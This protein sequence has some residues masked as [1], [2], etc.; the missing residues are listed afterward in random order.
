MDATK[1]VLMVAF[2]FPPCQSAGVQRT[3]K[4]C[5]YLP[6]LGWQPIVLTVQER[7]HAK[8][9]TRLG[10]PEE[11]EPFVF[12]AFGLDTRQHLSIKGKYLEMMARPDQFMTWYRPAVALGKKLI[13]QYQPDA[14]WSTFPYSTAHRIACKLHSW[15]GLPWIADFRDPFADLHTQTTSPNRAA[16]KVDESAVIAAQQLVF[17]TQKT[18]EL[19]LSSYPAL[20]Q[21][22]VNV[23]ENGY[24]EEVFQTVAAR[25]QN[26]SETAA[27]PFTL[28]YSGNLYGQG[29]S[30]KALFKAIQQLSERGVLVPGKFVLSFRGV[31]NVDDFQPALS[32]MGISDLVRFLPSVSYEESIAE[33]LT[34]DALL[35][36]QGEVF[37]NQIPGKAYEYLRSRKPILALTD[38]QGA[39]ADLLS[40]VPHALIADI[41]QTDAIADALE[42]LVTLEVKDNF[43]VQRYSRYERATALGGLL[44]RVTELE[45]EGS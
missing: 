15:S 8:I 31:S 36:L 41:E 39:T 9:D 18:A 14:L 26:E 45:L 33:M 19:Y 27:G 34:S 1:K 37:N 28:T 7:A 43:D 24:N 20:S 21:D 30:P 16:R 42:R 12:R 5:E 25:L 11:L 2:D 13:R 4:F 6:R 22:K 38:Q 35:L 3:L 44:D 29:R 32:E 10:I 17:T 23:I 40:D